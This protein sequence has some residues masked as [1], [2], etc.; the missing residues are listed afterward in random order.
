MSADGDT[1][2]ERVMASV[3]GP[4]AVARHQACEANY[5]ADCVK[6]AAMT[7]EQL[8]ETAAYY[9]H[10]CERCRFSR[11]E[12]VYDAVMAHNLIPEMIRRLRD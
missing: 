3:L 5:A 6:F 2:M 10:H 8:A 1:L 11:G 4:D 7:D 9:L 12:P